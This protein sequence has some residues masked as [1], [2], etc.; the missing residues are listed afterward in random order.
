MN[1]ERETSGDKSFHREFRKHFSRDGVD[2][3][4]IADVNIATSDGASPQSFASTT[5]N[6]SITQ[7]RGRAQVNRTR[8]TTDV[9]T[10]ADAEDPTSKG[11]SDD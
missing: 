4:V 11:A 6:V 8:H 2:L 10:E 3:S 7:R 1:E 5:Q 9:P